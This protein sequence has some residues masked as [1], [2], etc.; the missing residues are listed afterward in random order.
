MNLC[1]RTDMLNGF[2][3]IMAFNYVEMLN[4][5]YLMNNFNIRRANVLYFLW[6]GNYDRG[7]SNFLTNYN[8]N[9]NGIRNI[10]IYKI[11]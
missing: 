6:E 2:I 10:C 1:G 9:I 11:S 3:L 4:R 8:S 5:V 7:I